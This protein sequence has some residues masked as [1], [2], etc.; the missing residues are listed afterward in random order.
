[1]LKN[2]GMQLNKLLLQMQKVKSKS[3]CDDHL[4]CR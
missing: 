3:S 1:M 4:I 2:V